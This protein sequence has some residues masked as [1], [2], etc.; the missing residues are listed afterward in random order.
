MLPVPVCRCDGHSTAVQQYFCVGPE[1]G[2]SKN[3]LGPNRNPRDSSEMSLLSPEMAICIQV[4]MVCTG[5]H[6]RRT[7]LP[8]N[9]MC[10]AQLCAHSPY[11][12]P[13]ALPPHPTPPHPTQDLVPLSSS[14]SSCFN[15]YC[16]SSTCLRLHTIEPLNSPESRSVVVS[17][18][19]FNS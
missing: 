14:S 2:R 13:I 9:S 8:K 11:P 5:F 16:T 6:V 19:R 7:F 18:K 4:S 3:V 12:H 15:P 10:G 17:H 1:Q